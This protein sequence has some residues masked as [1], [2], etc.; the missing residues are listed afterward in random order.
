MSSVVFKCHKCDGNLIV[1][2]DLLKFI[3]FNKI[4]YNTSTSRDTYISIN[5]SLKV[6]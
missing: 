4:K 6:T 5:F 1:Q 3:F 2:P